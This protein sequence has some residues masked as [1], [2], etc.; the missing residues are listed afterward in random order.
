MVYNI[1]K[2]K[3]L[4]ISSSILAGINCS[5]IYCGCL[6][7]DKNKLTTDNNNSNNNNNNN[8]DKKDEKDETP[9]GDEE[10][11]QK[12]INVLLKLFN[13]K[14]TKLEKVGGLDELKITEEQIKNIKEKSQFKNIFNELNKIKIHND[15]VKDVVLDID[16]I[17]DVPYIYKNNNKD[18]LKFYN[19]GKYINDDSIVKTQEEYNQ[20]VS[21]LT[22]EGRMYH[23][24][25]YDQTILVNNG[26]V[27]SF[28]EKYIINNKYLLY[29][30]KNTFKLKDYIKYDTTY[31]DFLKECIKDPKIFE[32]CYLLFNDLSKLSSTLTVF[33]KKTIIDLD[34]LKN[35]PNIFQVESSESKENVQNRLK[36]FVKNLYNVELKT[37]EEIVDFFKKNAFEVKLNNNLSFCIFN[38]TIDEIEFKGYKKST[39]KPD[40]YKPENFVINITN[41]KGE[42]TT[43]YFVK[44][45][46]K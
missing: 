26:K 18:N 13:D 2:N 41:S 30:D 25:K 24:V 32:N 28:D 46:A 38:S 29:I 11:R 22:K 34:N 31:G 5:N 15:P 37:E 27:Y 6:C 21:N 10:Q 9:N 20:I 35:Y 45:E 8:G 17:P 7:D 33:K 16:N 12:A 42:M 36:N 3:N 44:E 39:E 23:F 40:I 4:I 1:K 19:F 43:Y 14:K